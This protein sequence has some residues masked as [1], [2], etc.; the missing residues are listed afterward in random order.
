M[1]SP[2][3]VRVFRREDSLGRGWEDLRLEGEMMYSVSE[4]LGNPSRTLI[5]R[6]CIGKEMKRILVNKIIFKESRV[7]FSFF[8]F[9]E[10]LSVLDWDLS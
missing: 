8:A 10:T 7:D 9:Y 5:Y 3:L 4:A 6:L 2:A 1:S